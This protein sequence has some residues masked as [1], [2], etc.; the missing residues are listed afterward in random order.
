MSVSVVLGDITL[1]HAD[2]IVNAAKDVYKRQVDAGCN[3]IFAD[4]FGHEPYMIQA[5]QELSLIHIFRSGT[6]S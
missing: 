3:I 5:A 1:S 4:S 2:A 6:A